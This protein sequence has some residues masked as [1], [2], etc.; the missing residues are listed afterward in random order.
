MTLSVSFQNMQSCRLQAQKVD[1]LWCRLSNNNMYPIICIIMMI[2]T[3]NIGLSDDM[4]IDVNNM[5]I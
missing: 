5:L 4:L 2:H 1:M 3:L